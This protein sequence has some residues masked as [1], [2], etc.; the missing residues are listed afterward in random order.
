MPTLAASLL[1]LSLAL[2][3]LW[4]HSRSWNSIR[5]REQQPEAIEF[6]GRQFRR[7]VQTSG[8]MVAIALVMFA[9]HW[10]NRPVT[11][12]AVWAVV[13][14]LVLWICV[15]AAVDWLHT[16]WYF[17]R[18]R[19]EN[20]AQRAALEAEMRRLLRHRSNGRPDNP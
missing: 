2:G 19:D 14:L 6:A 5:D 10:A 3:L 1:L 12:I 16:R 15:L 13:T 8:L 7:R 4:L 20:A 18:L 17:N 11:A 9:G